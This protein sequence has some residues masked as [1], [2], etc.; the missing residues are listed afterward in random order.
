[1]TSESEW[2][3]PDRPTFQL[4]LPYVLV[5]DEPVYMSQIAPFMHFAN[6]AWPGTIFGG[7]F[8]IDIWPRPLMW[9]FE[10]HDIEAPLVIK[11]GEPLFYVHFESRN[12]V[13][14]IQL[15]EVDA[16]EDLK[17]YLSHISGA[18]NYVDQTFS[19]F[20]EAARAR[21]ESLIVE[22]KSK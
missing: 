6:P 21:P 3:Y 12:P 17:T 4:K 7:R 11:R 15:V 10:W 5:A 1:M 14:P 13:R 18:V 16:T 2:R 20:E 9:A 19:L 22:K 8:P